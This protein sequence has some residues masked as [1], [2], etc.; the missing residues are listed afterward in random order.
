M[1]SQD[2]SG[3]LH[4]LTLERDRLA[5]NRVSSTGQ[6]NLRRR[7]PVSTASSGVPSG[8][9]RTGQTRDPIHAEGEGF[10]PPGRNGYPP[11]VF[12]TAEDV[13]PTC[14]FVIQLLSAP[15]I[16]RN[17]RSTAVY[18]RTLC[19]RRRLD[20][21]DAGDPL[22]GQRLGSLGPAWLRS[23]R[24]RGEVDQGSGSAQSGLEGLAAEGDNSVV[25]AVLQVEKPLE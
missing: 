3:I 12:K 24:A 5:R 21:T 19:D 6:S 11:A 10:E 13:A 1:G 14:M 22:E 23:E 2:A 4:Q 18:R 17:S 25:G 20:V 9:G 15:R 16:P 8:S 7:G